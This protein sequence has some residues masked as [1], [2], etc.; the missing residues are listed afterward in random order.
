MEHAVFPAI[1]F[2]KT[3]KKNQSA[4]CRVFWEKKEKSGT[5]RNPT[6]RLSSMKNRGGRSVGFRYG[7]G[8]ECL[9][10]S[11]GHQYTGYGAVLIYSLKHLK[12]ATSISSDSLVRSFHFLYMPKIG[13]IRQLLGLCFDRWKSF[14]RFETK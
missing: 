9:A 3:R 6:S 11:E 8:I 7:K 10:S 13:Q 1:R 5:G 4:G 14:M 12:A 2:I